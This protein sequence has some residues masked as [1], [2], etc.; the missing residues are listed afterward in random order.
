VEHVSAIAGIIALLGSGCCCLGML[1]IVGGIAYLLLKPP[2]TRARAT[3]V[4]NL[5]P[6]VVQA[7]PIVEPVKV[8]RTPVVDTK[9]AL[10]V[11]EVEPPKIVEAT[12]AIVE[13]EAK[14]P[15]TA[16]GASLPPERPI[17]PGTFSSRT[18]VPPSPDGPPAGATIMVPPP[19]PL[20]GPDPA[21]DVPEPPRGLGGRSPT[22][23]PEDVKPDDEGEE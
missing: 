3:I 1:E 20:E 13:A 14:R 23:V 7:T 12:K 22:I 15:D 19:L 18:M 9:P 8:T 16:T 6:P 5:K 2:K 4:E 11:E 21:V 10:V 17:D